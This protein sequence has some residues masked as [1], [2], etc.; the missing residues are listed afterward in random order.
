MI[1]SFASNCYESILDRT[2]NAVVSYEKKIVIRFLEFDLR[3]I[4]CA[5]FVLAPPILIS[6]F[7][8]LEVG[9]DTFNYL[10]IYNRIKV[11]DLFQYLNLY[12]KRFNYEI[13][14]QQILR[15][16]YILGG[17]NNLVK[18]FSSFLVVF[19]AWRGA[20]YYHK[21]FLI[22][23]G[24]C[25]FLF[26]LLSFSYSL[27]SVRNSIALSL[28]F[29][30]TQFVIEKKLVKYLICCFFMVMF[31]SSLI[32]AVAFYLF[33]YMDYWTSKK[34]FKYI[35]VI[36][37]IVAIV[38]QRSIANYILP[39]VQK[40]FF[41]YGGYSVDLTAN[42]GMGMYAAIILFLLPLVRWNAF[43]RKSP[44]WA[45]FLNSSL[46]YVFFRF[47]AYFNSW[48]IRLAMMPEILFCVLYSG[49][50]ILPIDRCEKFAWKIYIIVLSI[51]CYVFTVVVM[52]HGEIYP[53]V[54]D[55]TNHI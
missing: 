10:D 19:F 6:T 5:L 42:Y 8:A 30:G 25:M 21:K 23:S 53:Y 14:Y 7:R 32:V 3:K 13:G 44:A 31:H 41:R 11:Y 27:N 38:F 26:Y 18:F 50:M 33:N 55:F 34:Y 48:L 54:F 29:Y 28:F 17:G 2:S 47:L 52:N 20:L 9:T 15:L 51:A 24:M 37:I 49:L 46:L 43:L 1:S 12:G 35:S 39:V 4:I 45:F 22:S 16:S 40:N 36:T